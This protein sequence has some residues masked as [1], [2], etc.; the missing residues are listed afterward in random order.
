MLKIYD[1]DGFLTSDL[2]NDDD[3]RDYEGITIITEYL[4]TTDSGG[5]AFEVEEETGYGLLCSG[6]NIL[7]NAVYLFIIN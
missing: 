2:H 1:I 4:P 6:S 5:V 3:D 7:N